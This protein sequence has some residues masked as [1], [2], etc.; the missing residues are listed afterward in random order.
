MILA[1]LALL[2]MTPA[3]TAEFWLVAG[4]LVALITVQVIFWTKIQPANSFWLEET[5]LS[6]SATRFFQ[7]GKTSAPLDWTAARDQWE[8]SDILRALAATLGPVPADPRGRAVE[9]RLAPGRYL[10]R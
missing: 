8:R 2:I 3:G 7:T 1:T 9:A 6:S 5:E 10:F 4:A